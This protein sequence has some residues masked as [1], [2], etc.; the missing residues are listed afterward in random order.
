[1]EGLIRT[2]RWK[3]DKGP[4][5]YPF[6]TYTW[7]CLGYYPKI[8]ILNGKHDEQLIE[9]REIMGFPSEACSPTRAGHQNIS[10]WLWTTTVARG[11]RGLPWWVFTIRYGWSKHGVRGKIAI[12][13]V[14]MVMMM[15]MVIMIHW[16]RFPIYSDTPNK[17]WG[18]TEQNWIHPRTKWWFVLLRVV[19][20]FNRSMGYLQAKLLMYFV[21]IDVWDH[22]LSDIQLNL[23]CAPFVLACISWDHPVCE[24]A[25]I[26]HRLAHVSFKK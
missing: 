25:S 16:N 6:P 2:G 24:E 7:L 23:V 11:G 26:L 1:M 20:E 15:M 19:E 14:M 3:L 18:W 12:S 8:A 17:N 9:N 13:M 4:P 21:V 22:V 10:L 5:V